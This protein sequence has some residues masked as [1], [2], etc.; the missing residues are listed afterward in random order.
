MKTKKL[1]ISLILILCLFASLDSLCASSQCCEGG[2][3]TSTHHVRGVVEKV[4]RDRRQVTVHHQAIP[5]YMMEMTMDFTVKDPKELSYIRAGETI[6]FILHVEKV[7]SWIDEIR[8]VGEPSSAVQTGSPKPSPS[9]SSLKPGD[10]L[11]D[12]DFVAET[13]RTMHLSDFRGKAVALT[14][15]FTR[16]PLPD[17]CPRVNRNL[18]KARDI[19][20]SDKKSHASWEFLSLSFDGSYDRP[21]ILS[22]YAKEYR[23]NESDHWI[24]ATASPQM[25]AQVAAPLGLV[26]MK[27]GKSLAHNLRTVVV[28]PNGNLY[29]QWNDN[30]WKPEELA[31]AIQK[32]SAIPHVP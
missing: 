14:F 18:A 5:G 29:R 2:N 27:Q 21:E 25:L 10:P 24:F 4:S 7:D 3:S 9:T 28:D 30:G 15:F 13:G 16:C 31:E 17:F 20:F 12:G 26:I 23:G 11:P 32:A 8:V 22:S 19:L 6:T 1:L